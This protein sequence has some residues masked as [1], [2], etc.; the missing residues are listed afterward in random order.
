[1]VGEGGEADGVGLGCFECLEGEV[2]VA[3]G[4]GAAFVEAPE[5][6][7]GEFVVFGVAAGGFSEDGGDLGGVEDVV[8][9]LEGET[10]VVAELSEGVDFGGAGSGADGTDAAGAG[11]EAGGFFGVN[12]EEAL[13]VGGEGFG[14]EV[15]DLSANDPGAATGLG[16]FEDEGVGWMGEGGDGFGHPLTGEGE[17]GV[18]GEEGVGFAEANMGGGFATA[19]I[20]V[21]HAGKVVVYEGVGVE[22]FEGD[23]RTEGAGRG[24]PQAFADGEGENAAQAFTAVE[25]GVAHGFV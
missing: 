20:V 1:M 14:G 6:D 3:L 22:G 13:F 19:E 15:F 18:A 12:V 11:D 25:A 17:E 8:E 4:F 5:G 10:E 21:V 23:G 16:K 24:F 2:G 7:G 9:D